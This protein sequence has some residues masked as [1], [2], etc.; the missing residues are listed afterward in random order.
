MLGHLPGRWL[1]WLGVPI[2]RYGSPGRRQRLP[3]VPL[4]ADWQSRL[5][6]ES[7]NC[8]W[9]RLSSLFSLVSPSITVVGNSPA[10]HCTQ[11]TGSES[12]YKMGKRCRRP[13]PSLV[14]I[15]GK[16]Q[17]RCDKYNFGVAGIRWCNCNYFPTGYLNCKLQR[18]LIRKTA[19]Y[20]SSVTFSGKSHCWKRV[21]HSKL[22]WLKSFESKR[23]L[24]LRQP[25]V[26][27]DCQLD[28]MPGA[29]HYNPAFAV[30]EWACYLENDRKWSSWMQPT[31]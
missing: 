4:T 10:R 31:L 8:C 2:C 23:R 26:V 3:S 5:S 12:R 11:W 27:L 21:D 14:F 29:N 1:C 17:S 25:S 20:S 30:S 19:M 13:V 28:V 9:Q 24:R 16:G 7:E 15:H 18:T 6:R 22:E